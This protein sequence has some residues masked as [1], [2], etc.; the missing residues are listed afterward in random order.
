VVS[1]SPGGSKNQLNLLSTWSD[2]LAGVD[3]RLAFVLRGQD[4]FVRP[5]PGSVT[6]QIGPDISHL[7]APLTVDTHLDAD[8]APPYLTTIHHFAAPGTYWARVSHQGKT[9]DAPLTVI[10]PASTP[11]PVAGRPM[12]STPTPTVG[13]HRGVDPICTRQP[14]CPWHDVSLDTALAEHRPLAVLFATP[15]LCQTAT[16]GPVLDRLLELRSQF[17]SPIRFIHSEIYTNMSARTNAPAVQAYHLEGEPILFLAGADRIV[18][19]RIDGLYGR[20]EAQEAL[21]R[22][23]AG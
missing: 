17:E 2:Y 9:A 8:P 3:Q 6:L 12:I 23:A 7:G 19:Q 21:S 13:D 18:R 11:V 1:V 14:Q 15:A 5:D 10:D 22:L 20:G 16:C 4:N